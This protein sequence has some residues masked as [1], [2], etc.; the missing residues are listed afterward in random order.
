MRVSLNIALVFHHRPT[1]AGAVWRCGNIIR[2]SPGLD[3]TRCRAHS[4]KRSQQRAPA[5]VVSRL[6]KNLGIWLS[7]RSSDRW[8]PTRARRPPP[9]ATSAPCSSSGARRRRRASTRPWR[10]SGAARRRRRRP[11]ARRCPR[12][13]ARRA[14]HACNRRAPSTAAARTARASPLAMAA[15]S[16]KTASVSGQSSTRA[17]RGPST[18]RDTSWEGW[19]RWVRFGTTSSSET[20]NPTCSMES[21]SWKGL[22]GGARGSLRPPPRAAKAAAAL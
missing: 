9:T 17:L 16:R 3:S 20:A 18:S 10:S 21:S 5:W 11:R 19:R 14:L 15:C 8:P 13:R 12:R 1:P 6:A 7:T 2:L 4:A 22:Q